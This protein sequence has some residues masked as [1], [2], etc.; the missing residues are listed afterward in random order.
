MCQPAEVSP[1]PTTRLMLPDVPFVA[2]PERTVIEP[3]FPLVVAPV[4][5]ANAPDTPSVPAFAVLILNEPLE[6]A[7]P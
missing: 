5:N 2:A 1:L 7:V 3:L 6:V 4:V